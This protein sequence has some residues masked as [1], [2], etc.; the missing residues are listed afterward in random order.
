M[1]IIKYYQIKE[2]NKILKLDIEKIISKNDSINIIIDRLNNDYDYIEKI[3]R[4]KFY[5]AKKG[6]KIFRIQKK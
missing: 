6:E 1:G 5:M 2:Q 4:E 3:A